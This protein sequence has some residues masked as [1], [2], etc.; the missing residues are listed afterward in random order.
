VA[1]LTQAGAVSAAGVIDATLGMEPAYT[2][3]ADLDRGPLAPAYGPPAPGALAPLSWS[4]DGQRLVFAARGAS[5]PAPRPGLPAPLGALTGAGAAPGLYLAYLPPG[6]GPLPAVRSLERAAMAPGWRPDGA[7]VALDPGRRGSPPVLHRFHPGGR[8]LA[9][10]ALDPLPSGATYRAHWDGARPQGLLA[11]SQ[12]PAGATQSQA[13]Y[14]LIRF[15]PVGSPSPASST[16]P[17]SLTAPGA[18][19]QA[20]PGAPVTETRATERPRGLSAASDFLPEVA[21]DP[22]PWTRRP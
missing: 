15:G 21:P 12:G 6:G 13:E 2:Y 3:V 16:P 20:L 22:T 11:A 7:I 18:R 9:S 4:P 17:A 14:W 5:R 8:Q 1:L 10:A 19:P